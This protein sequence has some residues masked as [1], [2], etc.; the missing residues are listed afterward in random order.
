MRAR[1]GAAR[2]SRCAAHRAH[3]PCGGAPPASSCRPPT[4]RRATTA[5]AARSPC[6]R[7]RRG[8]ARRHRSRAA[9]MG[10]PPASPAAP[11]RS[12]AA[13]PIA[14]GRTCR[15]AT[16]R[17]AAARESAK[18]KNGRDNYSR[19]VERRGGGKRKI[20]SPAGERKVGGVVGNRLKNLT[21]LWSNG[22]APPWGLCRS[23]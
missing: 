7:S 16:T 14:S 1:R 8:R 22:N 13:R 21:S 18:R 4:P 9:A 6:P 19:C 2:R 3:S 17:S 12:A 5:S 10:C 23:S 20:H 11:T 15:E